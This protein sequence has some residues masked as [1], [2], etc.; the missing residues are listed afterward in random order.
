MKKNLGMIILIAIL[1]IITSFLAYVV[2]SKQNAP[3]QTFNLRKGDVIEFDEYNIEAT[4][5]NVASTL[6]EDKDTCISPGE[7]EVSVKINYEGKIS[8]YTLKSVSNPKE[9]IVK[10]NYYISVKYEDKKIILDIN[11]K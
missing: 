10:S 1:M 3:K 7:I 11:E 9:R 6:C 2:V 4:I 5:L 8:N